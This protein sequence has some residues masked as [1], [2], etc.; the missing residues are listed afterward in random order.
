LEELSGNTLRHSVV[1][2]GLEK[3]ATENNTAKASGTDE[4][5]AYVSD[6]DY[7]LDWGG[8]SLNI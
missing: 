2:A 8:V 4:L 3:E 5:K 7:D 1:E 6:E